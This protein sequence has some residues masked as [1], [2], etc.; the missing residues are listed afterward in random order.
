MDARGGVEAKRQFDLLRRKV[1]VL[2]YVPEE[3]IENGVRYPMLTH[4]WNKGW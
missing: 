3:A 1:W 4:A 2:L